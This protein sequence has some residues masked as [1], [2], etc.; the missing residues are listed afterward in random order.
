MGLPP[1]LSCFSVPSKIMIRA[2]KLSPQESLKETC[3]VNQ[4]RLELGLHALASSPANIWE[5]GDTSD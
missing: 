3:R 1:V 4:Q 5:Q 2:P